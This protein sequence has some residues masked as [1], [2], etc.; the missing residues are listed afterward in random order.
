M[1]GEARRRRL[2]Y[3]TEGVER[4]S[5]VFTKCVLWYARTIGT[6]E[7]PWLVRTEGGETWLCERVDIVRG[8]TR[9]LDEEDRKKFPDS[10]RGVVECKNLLAYG[11]R[12][13][14][15]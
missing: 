2:G 4:P 8:R 7:A 6:T 15:F 14:A 11:A 13:L 5:H 10:P 9:L 1:A 12:R 3:A